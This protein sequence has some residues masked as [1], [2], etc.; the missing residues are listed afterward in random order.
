[1]PLRVRAHLAGKLAAAYVIDSD[2]SLARAR[3]AGPTQID[4]L[5]APAQDR[6]RRL[7]EILLHLQGAAVAGLGVVRYR[8]EDRSHEADVEG[9]TVEDRAVDLVVSPVDLGLRHSLPNHH[10]HQDTP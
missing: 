4:F 7:H 8:S 1:Q 10:L 5:R 6:R 3:V 2:R 9:L